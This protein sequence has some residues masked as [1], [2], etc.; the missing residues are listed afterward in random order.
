[1]GTGGFC[2]IQAT[3]SA[4][5]LLCLLCLLSVALVAGTSAESR[6]ADLPG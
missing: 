4:L 3:A 2:A 1:L 6:V 5:S